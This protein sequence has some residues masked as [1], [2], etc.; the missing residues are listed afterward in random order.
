M[1]TI[2]C[3]SP[4]AEYVLKDKVQQRGIADLFEIRSAATSSEE[5]W[6]GVGNPVYPPARRK[7]AE[8][9]INCEG[10]HATL[11]KRSDYDYYDYLIGMDDENRYEMRRIL[12]GD[13]DGKLSQLLD[14]TDRPGEVADPWYTGNFDATWRDVQEGT[15]GLLRYLGF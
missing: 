7:M 4:M 2:V 9:G 10:H 11:L 12:G 14:Y 1:F 8:N 6:R 15:E 3:R 5:I 13:P